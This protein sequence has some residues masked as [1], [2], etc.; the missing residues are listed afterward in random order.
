MQA[1]VKQDAACIIEDSN[2]VDEPLIVEEIVQVNKT[3]GRLT[4]YVERWKEIFNDR[5]ILS[6]ISGY[7]IPFIE[8]PT[9]TFILEEK[10]WALEEESL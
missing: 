8:T 1:K 4:F 2:A 5:H 9:Q 7:K 10:I 6:Y 3:A